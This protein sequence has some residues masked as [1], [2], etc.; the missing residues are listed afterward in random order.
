MPN[1]KSEN[2]KKDY[3]ASYAWKARNADKQREYARNCNKRLYDYKNSISYD[4]VAK[5]FLKCMRD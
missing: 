5:Q 4:Y 3:E 2:N 1:T